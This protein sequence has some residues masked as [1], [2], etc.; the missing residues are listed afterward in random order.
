V[1]RAGEAGGPVAGSDD[2]VGT[3]DAPILKWEMMGGGSTLSSPWC[4][5]WMVVQRMARQR[6][7]AA[8]VLGLVWPKVEEKASGLG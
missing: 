7:E 2:L 5:R 3:T 4:E 8:V 6:M 1:S